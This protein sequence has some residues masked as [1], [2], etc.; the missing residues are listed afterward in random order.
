[1]VSLSVYRVPCLSLESGELLR[2]THPVLPILLDINYDINATRIYNQL[3]GNGATQQ[4]EHQENLACFKNITGVVTGCV[5]EHINR[6]IKMTNMRDSALVSALPELGGL[7]GRVKRGVL[8]PSK[9]RSARKRALAKGNVYMERKERAIGSLIAIAASI[10]SLAGTVTSSVVFASEIDTLKHTFLA[11][12]NQVELDYQVTRKI[13]E[14][15]TRV[16]NEQGVVS[17][18]I[19]QL[20]FNLKFL[21]KNHQCF[22][23]K[24]YVSNQIGEIDRFLDL[25]FNDLSC[26]RL[27]PRILPEKLLG[28]LLKSLTDS[29]NSIFSALPLATY[30]EARVSI[31]S[32]N[33][34]RRTIRLLIAFPS[35]SKRPEY[36]MINF[37][38]PKATIRGEGTYHGLQ[39]HLDS[40]SL[41]LPLR[42]AKRKNF[43][44]TK[45]TNEQIRSLM[46]PAECTTI[47]GLKTCKS[48]IPASPRSISCLKGIF[49]D[50]PKLLT[51]CPVT[52][53][54]EVDHI[55]LDVQR[56]TRGL[57]LC[58]SGTYS[59]YGIEG[60]GDFERRSLLAHS[61]S[62]K[63]SSVCAYI[64]SSY[65]N[66]VVQTENGA[67]KISQTPIIKMT[68]LLGSRME[69]YTDRHYRWFRNDDSSW[70][71]DWRNMSDIDREARFQLLD[72]KRNLTTVEMATKGIFWHHILIY[73]FLGFVGLLLL[74]GF[75]VMIKGCRVERTNVTPTA[76]PRPEMSNEMM[77]EVLQAAKVISDYQRD[78]LQTRSSP[79]LTSFR[80]F[81][82]RLSKSFRKRVPRRPP[83]FTGF[84]YNQGSSE[85]NLVERFDEN[86]GTLGG[87]RV[88]NPLAPLEEGAQ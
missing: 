21:K 9:L 71:E 15:L 66:L 18:K 27:T 69:H 42:Y 56:G 12:Q 73:I 5:D 40:M 48:F 44:V 51:S 55:K 84:R 76:P 32:A 1:M 50:D 31:V 78:H 52:E 45:L 86:L 19:D 88:V 68:S 79:Q 43:D 7:E 16:K 83:P 85:G 29:K 67:F 80:R 4:A 65:N 38:S 36:I 6:T 54:N 34:Q 33:R 63:S 57:G 28:G 59:V 70:L 8:Q 49:S 41:A 72:M 77:N 13:G 82:E 64:P 74:Y 35:V 47:Q 25:T 62:Q 58:S 75:T 10:M 14:G 39:L 37:L 11:V 46:T 2:Q 87:N 20:F 3:F 24:S 26:S 23:G 81:G 60:M 30:E 53:S 17:L 61:N 22:L